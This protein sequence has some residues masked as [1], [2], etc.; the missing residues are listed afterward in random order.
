ML[1]TGGRTKDAT[2][3]VGGDVGEDANRVKVV[4]R[5]VGGIH[6]YICICGMRFIKVS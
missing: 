2:R 1:G 6:M 4:V 5:I 3:D